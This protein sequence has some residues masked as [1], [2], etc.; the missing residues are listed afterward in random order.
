[1]LT[2]C[3][4]RLEMTRVQYLHEQE[5][6]A[7]R[8]PPACWRYLVLAVH[9]VRR[10]LPREFDTQHAPSCQ[11]RRSHFVR[12]KALCAC[13]SAQDCGCG[14]LHTL[15]E[16]GSVA[17]RE[18]DAHGKTELEA[19]HRETERCEEGSIATAWAQQWS[20]RSVSPRVEDKDASA[21]ADE[22][23][24]DWTGVRITKRGAHQ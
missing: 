12:S 1:M 7:H 6:A 20:L 22:R 14:R 21:F 3:L 2:W 17:V 8:P 9:R 16:R 5:A 11:R 10:V 4:L 24:T 18:R 15:E 13:E 19:G 23:Q